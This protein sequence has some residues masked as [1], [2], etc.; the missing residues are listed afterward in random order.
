MQVLTKELK[1]WTGVT[2]TTFASMLSLGRNAL[3]FVEVFGANLGSQ[4]RPTQARYSAPPGG[5][6]QQTT[7]HARSRADREFD[8]RPA[9][10]CWYLGSTVR[11]DL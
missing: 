4:L 3:A 10:T 7:K 11:L 5:K 9:V 2:K 1:V 8:A 6:G